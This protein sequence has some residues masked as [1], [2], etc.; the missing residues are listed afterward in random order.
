MSNGWYHVY[1]TRSILT[2]VL[3]YIGKFNILGVLGLNILHNACIT[4]T[5]HDSLYVLSIQGLDVLPGKLWLPT[6][7]PLFGQPTPW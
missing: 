5:F 3:N 7:P 1:I 4:F 6:T 2:I